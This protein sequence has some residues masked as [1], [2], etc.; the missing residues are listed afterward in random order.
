MSACWISVL[1]SGV[2]CCCVGGLAGALFLAIVLDFAGALLRAAV[3]AFL[4]GA[5][6]VWGVAGIV[7]PQTR[8]NKER[9]TFP[10]NG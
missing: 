9:I 8:S 6:A 7:T 5:F 10:G 1:R 3:V 2:G 4:R